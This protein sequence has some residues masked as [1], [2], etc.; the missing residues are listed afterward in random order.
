MYKRDFIQLPNLFTGSVKSGS[1]NQAGNSYF[2]SMAIKIHGDRIIGKNSQN[3][4]AGAFSSTDEKYV[5]H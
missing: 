4:V 3:H 5:S 1:V 2:P